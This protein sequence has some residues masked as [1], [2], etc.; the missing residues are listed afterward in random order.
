MD[1]NFLKYLSTTPVL[2]TVWLSFRDK[3]TGQ[4]ITSWPYLG[5]SWDQLQTLTIDPS[6]APASL[7]ITITV[8]LVSFPTV[9]FAQDLIIG[10]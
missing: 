6:T 5:L 1:S 7:T 3:Q 8:S 2:I 4:I 9:T 10:V